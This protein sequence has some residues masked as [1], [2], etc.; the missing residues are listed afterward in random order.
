ME[1]ELYELGELI[2]AVD[3]TESGIEDHNRSQ[4]IMTGNEKESA[5]PCTFKRGDRPAKQDNNALF[6]MLRTKS[7]DSIASTDG[8]TQR[9]KLVGVPTI[10]P[11]SVTHQNALQTD[12][13]TIN[14]SYTGT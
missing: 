5:I 2:D 6:T 14:T 11:K 12:G 13:S 1:S 3:E 8:A 7:F 9:D 4:I 10:I